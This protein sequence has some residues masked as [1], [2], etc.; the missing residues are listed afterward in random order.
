M[1]VLARESLIAGVLAAT[2]YPINAEVAS[3]EV[4]EDACLPV[5]K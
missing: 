2:V 1:K 4:L 5:R 3:E